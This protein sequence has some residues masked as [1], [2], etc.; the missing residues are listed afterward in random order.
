M[1]SDSDSENDCYGNVAKKLQKMKDKYDREVI[2][3]MDILDDSLE[4]NEQKSNSFSEKIET[5]PKTPPVEDDPDS[6]VYE[7]PDVSKIVVPNTNK[8]VTR[9]STRKKVATPPSDVLPPKRGKKQKSAPSNLSDPSPESSAP[10]PTVVPSAPVPTIVPS[11]PAP[12]TGRKSRGRGRLTQNLSS[13]ATRARGR[14]GNR[15]RG[16]GRRNR[17]TIA[18]YFVGLFSTYENIPTYSIGNTEEYPDQSNNQPLFSKPSAKSSNEEVI[19][20]EEDNLLTENEELSVKVY[21]QS[22]EF[23]KFTIRK[24]QK[25]TQIFD[26]FANKENVRHDNLLLTYNERVLKP[27]DTPDSISY[28]IVKFIEGGITNCSVS[29]FMSSD[30]QN[31]G[32]KLKF[33]CQ[34]VKKPLEIIIQLDEKMSVAMMKCAEHLEKPLEKLKFEFDGDCISGLFLQLLVSYKCYNNVKTY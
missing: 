21:W 14:G 32:I 15:S 18:D 23:F 28:S 13:P 26:Y 1:S 27:D 2:Q 6:P 12:A 29:E 33:Q 7:L 4:V 34:N 19:V 8:R 20:V 17:Q 11:A 10:V 16:R 24:Y 22:T 31:N 3:N 25:L 9:S 5:K 30:N